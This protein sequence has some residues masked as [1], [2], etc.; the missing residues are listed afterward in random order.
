MKH[1]RNWLIKINL[2][3]KK[4]GRIVWV[5]ETAASLHINIT[6]KSI[7]IFICGHFT[8]TQ[9]IVIKLFVP[10][11]FSFGTCWHL[12]WLQVR[13]EIFFVEACVVFTNNIFYIHSLLRQQWE[14]RFYL[15]NNISV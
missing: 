14:L 1:A 5:K 8:C 9:K 15:N 10:F 11:A 13:C 6:L 2:V 12:V 4:F 3:L 7:S